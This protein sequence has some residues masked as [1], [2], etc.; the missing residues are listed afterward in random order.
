MR[1][2][3][4]N[5]ALIQKGPPKDSDGYEGEQRWCTIN[6]TVF[7]YVKISGLWVSQEY[8]KGGRKLSEQVDGKTT[9]T[10]VQ[11]PT[12]I[13]ST[14]STSSQYGEFHHIKITGNITDALDN[15]VSATTVVA[16]PQDSTQA[17]SDYLKN[18]GSDILEGSLAILGYDGNASTGPYLLN[19]TSALSGHPLLW[20][21]NPDTGISRVGVGVSGSDV[22][23]KFQVAGVL[24]EA[25][26]WVTQA[27]A[28][29]YINMAETTAPGALN[30][31]NWGTEEVIRAYSASATEYSSLGVV[32]NSSGLLSSSTPGMVLQLDEG[33]TTGAQFI[34]SKTSHIDLGDWNAKFRTLFVDELYAET[35]V[36]QDVMATI[37]GRIMVAPT[38]KL[39]N[40]FI[41]MDIYEI[42]EDATDNTQIHIYTKTPNT[43]L[44][45]DGA[46]VYITDVGG[47]T[48]LNG[49]NWT[50]ESLTEGGSTTIT[51]ITIPTSVAEGVI[52]EVDDLTDLY[53]VSTIGHT[54]T[55]KITGV[56]GTT[57]LN[58]SYWSSI[59]DP[60]SGN[61][62]LAWLGDNGIGDHSE[63]EEYISGGTVTCAEANYI[64]ID[65][66]DNGYTDNSDISAYTSGGV[67]YPETIALN[68]NSFRVGEYLLLKS[69]PTGAPQQECVKVASLS[70]GTSHTIL[71]SGGMQSTPQS[72]QDAHPNRVANTR[73]TCSSAHG[74]SDG[75]WVTISGTDG[76][77]FD[78]DDPGYNGVHKIVYLTTG[79]NHPTTSQFDI[80]AP[81]VGNQTGSTLTSAPYYYNVY[82]NEDLT[83]FNDWYAGDAIVSLGKNIGEGWL[84]LTSTR[85]TMQELGPTMSIN[86]R[87]GTT[88]WNDI[89]P[90]VAVGNLESFLDYSSDTPGIAIGDDISAGTISERKI[91]TADGTNGVRLYNV[92][93]NLYD[94]A[95][96]TVALDSTGN[97]SMGSN[98]SAANTTSF[99]F[100][101]E[102]TA[103]NS[104]AFTAGDVLF[105]SNSPTRANLFWDVSENTGSGALKIR[106]G[107]DNTHQFNHDG[108]GHIGLFKDG[109]GDKGL[110]WNWNAVTSKYDFEFRGEIALPD[111]TEIVGPGMNWRGDWSSNGAGTSYA[112]NDSV[113]YNGS[114]YMCTTAIASSTEDNTATGFPSQSSYWDVAASAGSG[115]DPVTISIS[116]D[117]QTFQ[118][119]GDNVLQSPSSAY[120]AITPNCQNGSGS[121]TITP[122]GVLREGTSSSSSTTNSVGSNEPVYLHED[123]FDTARGTDS[124]LQITMVYNGITDYVTIY[125]LQDGSDGD[126]TDAGFT[127]FLDNSNHTFPANKNGVVASG[128]YA[129]GKSK[130][131]FY[132]G[133]TRVYYNTG[134]NYPYY[135]VGTPSYTDTDSD[136]TDDIAVSTAGDGE[137]NESILITPSAFQ[138]DVKST[139]VTIPI[140]YKKDA[141]TSVVFDRVVSY[142]KSIAGQDNKGIITS[143]TS[144]V[145]TYTANGDLEPEDDAQDITIT[146][147]PQNLS[148]ED[149]SWTYSPSGVSGAATE[150]D[151]TLVQ[152]EVCT[153]DVSDSGFEQCTITAT[154]DGFSDS[155]T[156]ITLT[157]ASQHLNSIKYDHDLS[158]SISNPTDP[159]EFKWLN[160]EQLLGNSADWDAVDQLRVCVKDSDSGT[161][162]NFY[163][164][165][166]SVATNLEFYRDENNY[167]T[168]RIDSIVPGTPT[169]FMKFYLTNLSGT[170][171]V[172]GSFSDGVPVQ[173]NFNVPS[174]PKEA[175]NGYLT[176]ESHT[177][178]CSNTGVPFSSQLA[179]ATGN[180]KCFYGVQDVTSSCTFSE[181]SETACTGTITAAG[182]Y[183]LDTLNAGTD[184]LGTYTV[185]ASYTTPVGEVVTIDKTFTTT[186]SIAGGAGPGATVYY[187]RSFDGSTI[188]NSA[189]TIRL[190]ATKVEGGVGE[191]FLTSGDIKMYNSS[192]EVIAFGTGV[193]YGGSGADPEYD[194]VLSHHFI[195]GQHTVSL[196]DGNLD[197]LD[198]ISLVDITDGGATVYGTVTSDN[199]LAWTQGPHGDF[200]PDPTTT[201]LTV[202]FYQNGSSIATRTCVVTRTGVTLDAPTPNGTGGITYTKVGSGSSVLTLEFSHLSTDAAVTETLYVCGYGFGPGI[203]PYELS[204]ATGG[205]SDLL[206]GHI[207]MVGE[208][209]FGSTITAEAD[210]YA[211]TIFIRVDRYDTNQIDRKVWLEQVLVG[212]IIRVRTDGSTAEYT[213]KVVDIHNGL[214][215][216]HTFIDFDVV[217]LSSNG[218]VPWGSTAI[219]L[220][221]LGVE[222]YSPSNLVLSNETH[223]FASD[224]TGVVTSSGTT[225]DAIVYTEGVNSTSEWTFTV[226]PS[227]SADYVTY[228][229]SGPNITN[230]VMATADAS[231]N[232]LTEASLLIT[233]T[234]AGH[235]SIQRTMT[236]IKSLSGIICTLNGP[237]TFTFPDPTSDDPFGDNYID[238]NWTYSGGN[239]TVQLTDFTS[240]GD[241]NNLSDLSVFGSGDAQSGAVRLTYSDTDS[242]PLMITFTCPDE[243][244]IKDT[245]TI[246]RL[247]QPAPALINAP[248]DERANIGES[249]PYLSDEGQYALKNSSDDFTVLYTEV[250]YFLFNERDANG[251]HWGNF[252]NTVKPG[253]HFRFYSSENSYA[254]FRVTGDP[255]PF[256]NAYKIPATFV[257]T[258]EAVG[259][260]GTDGS[261]MD[262][263]FQWHWGIKGERGENGDGANIPDYIFDDAPMYPDGLTLTNSHLGYASGGTWV[264]YIDGDGDFFL[265]GDGTTP[266]E[267]YQGIAWDHSTSSLIVNGEIHIGNPEDINITELGGTPPWAETGDVNDLVTN[268]DAGV[269]TTGSFAANRVSL[270]R[271]N[272]VYPNPVLYGV[273]GTDEWLEY[274]TASATPAPGWE[275]VHTAN[276]GSATY[277]ASGAESSSVG[278]KNRAI[279]LSH[280]ISPSGSYSYSSL[281]SNWFAVD[282][283]N[284]YL[285][286]MSVYIGTTASS[287]NRFSGYL[288]I[289]SSDTQNSGALNDVST[290]NDDG[291]VA[292]TSDNQYAKY[293]HNQDMSSYE[294]TWHEVSYMIFGANRTQNEMKHKAGVGN[295]D[296]F[297]TL[298]GNMQMVPD[299]KYLRLVFRNYKGDSYGDD[300]TQNVPMYFHNVQCIPTDGATIIDGG[301][302]QTG[303][304]KGITIE[305][306]VFDSTYIVGGATRVSEWTGASSTDYQAVQVLDQW[307]LKCN[308]VVESSEMDFGEPNTAEEVLYTDMYHY[309]EGQP[310]SGDNSGALNRSASAVPQVVVAGTSPFYIV[311]QFTNDGNAD[312]REDVYFKLFVGG[313]SYDRFYVSYQTRIAPTT[314][315]KGQVYVGL[316]AGSTP[317]TN[318]VLNKSSSND[319]FISG[320]ETVTLNSG[321]TVTCFATSAYEDSGDI[322]DTRIQLFLSGQTNGM[323]GSAANTA[324]TVKCHRDNSGA[325]VTGRSCIF[326]KGFFKIYN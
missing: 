162:T 43:G 282:P 244:N 23:G 2:I 310:A 306:V 184:V 200:D 286:K 199:G 183:S 285:V 127:A 133:T 3:K 261:T 234:R 260:A 134:T 315:N 228:Q 139:T 121:V 316:A 313:G 259:N 243:S 326:P 96:Q 264:S 208:G 58:D 194:C 193:G 56:V 224:A 57:Q 79:S 221:L 106:S 179:T 291:S 312:D 214:T 132:D 299:T 236:L 60:S 67:L 151:G 124:H 254:V 297:L 280:D 274:P 207:T 266:S 171:T 86:R 210:N 145:V 213:G 18:K 296:M 19:L 83:G 204:S 66:N 192:G 27:G 54:G 275:A 308:A 288:G 283:A 252:Y 176:N 237:Q 215:S 25:A 163:A 238:L 78:P 298:D 103:Y 46:K 24:Q 16:H 12:T 278:G 112:I 37:G 40:D 300:N 307:Y 203:F 165:L 229:Q 49:S 107:T 87:S 273:G 161:Q 240:A 9:Q 65:S 118:Y 116:A 284:D 167:A 166:S 292:G 108:S 141:S 232:I 109:S 143:T 76:T 89:E 289:Q 219:T 309:D 111:G 38:S 205:P 81:F 323:Y 105:G 82:R 325:Y 249:S 152:N 123:D 1:E 8:S 70:G 135:E 136:G 45:Y 226:T 160:E 153:I 157:A 225:C 104:E 34:P 98:L 241:D 168:F 61:I 63:F 59:I 253:T 159:G 11:T 311:T 110:K 50:V 172:L 223:V 295:H 147:N 52:I 114:T 146:A 69:A 72:Y 164:S 206:S 64:T 113:H 158:N 272:L 186:K 84:E 270:G 6:G 189:G 230:I 248:Y 74:L 277:R 48:E 100:F 15:T 169:S 174:P 97:L 39:N 197:V 44:K 32:G 140:T 281:Y 62:R 30:V 257:S 195:D 263:V 190:R 222:G 122:T 290:V 99:S 35:L 287:S 41:K 218:A 239:T 154:L 187:I 29:T 227:S 90:V 247:D 130:V 28:A 212:D 202:T 149:V 102:D 156:I 125:R 178:S 301:T 47:A 185:R 276:G 21:G 198:T 304:I 314:P 233:A 209:T 175:F 51:D 13:A 155:V 217:E 131:Y 77:P 324:Q 235:A 68:H 220:N 94:G 293:F 177:I 20:V 150:S 196:K 265:S 80:A 242:Y 216:T 182:A 73:I 303:V 317:V 120:I 33:S 17:H 117:Y 22:K 258:E 170:G 115:D 14:G 188:Q 245:L 268:I 36:A 250:D 92:D 53:G 31:K 142:S 4:Q 269:I 321:L 75:D 319:F 279:V 318:N 26:F 71:N 262:V 302:I 320:T 180:F 85:T 305:G 10:V 7:H 256:F 5:V 267:S 128:D 201:T 42:K 271:V 119:S 148:S 138:N 129:A 55:V 137:A 95:A 251:M 93:L 255:N 294:G 126:A 191:T 211:D 231:S 181:V 101:S 246:H 91:I 322:I 144:Y 173:I 88:S